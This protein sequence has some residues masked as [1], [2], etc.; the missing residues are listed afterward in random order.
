M[1]HVGAIARTE[2]GRV[3]PYDAT[4]A[5]LDRVT[6]DEF[7]VVV[8]DGAEYVG[9]LTPLDVARHQH[10]LVIDCLGGKPAVDWEADFRDAV[11]GM[12]E[13]QVNVL[14]VFRDGRFCAVVTHR[15][16]VSH[17]CAVSPSLEVADRMERIETLA[18]LAGGIAHDLNN[19]LTMLSLTVS[20]MPDAGEHEK[21]RRLF[22]QAD[23]GLLRAREL[24][25]QLQAFSQGNPIS[26]S[27]RDPVRI[28]RAATEFFL[29]GSR[30]AVQFDLPLR[31][32]ALALPSGLL[33]RVI[34]NLVLNA[35]HAMAGVGKLEVIAAVEPAI[36]GVARRLRITVADSGPGI[37]AEHL[38]RIFEHGYTTKPSG[39]G[40]GLAVVRDLVTRYGGQIEARSIPGQGAC[41]EV[42]LPLRGA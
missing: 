34:E 7:L 16:I 20:Q 10:A 6:R 2:F 39:T 25:A 3:G 29:R 4:A 41:F 19:V 9:I 15:D 40:L 14:P 23:S 42:T 36:D 38:P 30:V 32:D 18:L 12:A 33:E 37:A 13:Q 11:T 8:T 21:R 35:R 26:A 5:V 27:G 24:V 22:E 31:I 28:I 1:I 17:L